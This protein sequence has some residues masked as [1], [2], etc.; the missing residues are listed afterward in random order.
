[1]VVTVA[2]AF[3]AVKVYPPGV[4][5]AACPN[6][7]F[8]GTDGVNPTTG[9]KYADIPQ[10]KIYPAGLPAAACPNFPYCNQAPAP[11]SQQYVQTG[12]VQLPAGVPAAACP[13]FPYC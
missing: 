8:C 12:V 2:S 5:P 7:P 11:Y 4:S 6:F 13:N 3:P 9:I 1:M 10:V